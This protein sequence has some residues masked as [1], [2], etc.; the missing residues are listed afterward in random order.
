MIP[1][2]NA[3]LLVELDGQK[4]SVG[5][6]V[7]SLSELIQENGAMTLDFAKDESGCDDIWEIRRAFSYSLRATG[8]TKLNEDIVVPRG[9]LVDLV[10]FCEDLQR[11]INMPI[12]CFGHAGDGNIHVNVMVEDIH[13]EDNR[14]MLCCVELCR[15]MSNH[16][17]PC[18][19]HEML[20]RAVLCRDALILR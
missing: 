19:S 10:K 4:K 20:I 15:T 7:E 9:R 3:F 11:E 1:E 14:A 12:A 17:E 16:V 6:E 8:L 5:I 2:G 18:R 13:I